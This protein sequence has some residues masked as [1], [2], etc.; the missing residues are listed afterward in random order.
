MI[1]VR[2]L[3]RRMGLSLSTVSELAGGLADAGLLERREG[4]RRSAAYAAGAAR[5]LPAAVR[6]V[7][8][9]AHRPPDPGHGPPDPGRTRGLPGRSGRLGPRGRA[10]RRPEALTPRPALES[11]V[12][13]VVPGGRHTIVAASRRY[14][15]MSAKNGTNTTVE[16][17]GRHARDV[18]VTDRHGA[19]P[20]RPES[21]ALHDHLIA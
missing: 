18:G 11:H 8:R 2:D 6:G 16:V 12:T 5:A 21:K 1:A 4:P 15:C 14:P 19:P 3:A 13:Y 10:V 7:L 20:H 9:P 17:S